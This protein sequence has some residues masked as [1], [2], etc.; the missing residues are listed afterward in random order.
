MFTLLES[1]DSFLSIHILYL[2]YLVDAIT[3][4]KASSLWVDNN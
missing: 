2:A 4:L 1:S 3:F